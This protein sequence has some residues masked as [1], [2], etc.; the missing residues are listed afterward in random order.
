MLEL[1]TIDEARE[2]LRLDY[3]DTG[4][5][6]DAWLEVMIPAIS[7]AVALWLKDPARL[8]TPAVDSN[9]DPVLDDNGDPVPALD[10]EG[11]PIVRPSVRAAV[12]I[13]LDST[14]QFRAGEGRDN[15][16]DPSAGYG[17]V[18]NKTSTALLA[19]LRR[20]TVG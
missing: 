3:D 7:E 16:V 15:M 8:Y 17:Y 12:L 13:E 4:G 5:P 18:L 20:P 2:H 1:I 11:N 10:G 14:Y 6:D 19:P 9:G